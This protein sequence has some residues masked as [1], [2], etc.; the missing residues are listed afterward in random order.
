[1]N[2]RHG[3]FHHTDCSPSG[4]SGRGRETPPHDRHEDDRVVF[5]SYPNY[6]S[7]ISGRFGHPNIVAIARK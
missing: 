1:M 5:E 6:L 3:E 2:E 4:P 7:D